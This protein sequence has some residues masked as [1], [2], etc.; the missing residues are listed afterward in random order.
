[1]IT[2]E[3]DALVVGAG[4]GGIYQLHRLV[5][6]GLRCKTVEVAGDVGGTWY[7]NKY[8]GCMSDSWSV[9]YRYS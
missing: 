9:I 3:L 1:M 6:E 7:W 5:K 4:L 8:P 2:I